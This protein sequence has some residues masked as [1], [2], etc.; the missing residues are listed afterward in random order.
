MAKVEVQSLDP[1][2]T[3]A[4]QIRSV[5]HLRFREAELSSEDRA[6]GVELHRHVAAET[7][8][9]PLRERLRQ[10]LT[11]LGDGVEMDAE[12]VALVAAQ[13]RMFGN[14]VHEQVV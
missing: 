14:T 6:G 11:D 9:P 1:E 2:T 13:P 7:N 8:A 5:A 10:K 3:P 4:A 12:A